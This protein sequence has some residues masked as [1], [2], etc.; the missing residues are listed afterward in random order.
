MERIVIIGAGGFGR[1]VL[2]LIDRNLY[3]PVGF[4][5]TNTPQFSHLSLPVLGDD[6]LI[7]DL[8]KEDIASCVC[9]ALGNMKKRKKIFDIV[10]K[11]N[12][13]LPPIIHSSAV[14]L[15]EKFIGEGAIIYPNVVVMDNCKI[16][17]GVLLNSGV[18]LGHDVA[19]GDFSNINPG[20]NMGGYINVGR[21]V[22]VGIG[23][24]IREKVDVGDEAIIGAGSVVLKD[25]AP[26]TTVYGVPA[27]EKGAD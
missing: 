1:E 26:K 20:A 2:Q 10:T 24:S 4:I 7:P 8:H 11:H 25:V 9:V 6:S 22:L 18:T 16:G 19:I 15:T 14:I 5:D 3:E 27:K 23:S 21:Q 17:R 13:K 12:L